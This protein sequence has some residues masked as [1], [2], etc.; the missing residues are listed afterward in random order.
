MITKICSFVHI[1]A[2]AFLRVGK[3][4]KF[5]LSVNIMPKNAL[6]F[7]SERKQ[8]MQREN[9]TKISI[10]LSLKFYI[11]C[12]KVNIKLFAA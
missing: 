2:Y 1:I 3:P 7:K 8:N 9:F 12:V 5:H 4:L 6:F 10:C 11:G